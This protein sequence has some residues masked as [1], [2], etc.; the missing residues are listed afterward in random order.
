MQGMKAN[1][2]KIDTLAFIL[3]NFNIPL[4]PIAVP[5]CTMALFANNVK[6]VH[7]LC[8]FRFVPHLLK[9]NIVELSP[10]SVLLYN[11]K[12]LALDCPKEKKGNSRMYILYLQCTMQMFYFH[13]LTLLCPQTCRLLQIFV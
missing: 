6:Q 7:K 3:C 5:D 1:S 2:L 4:T 9:P 11:I 10:T 13:T 12:N 8:D